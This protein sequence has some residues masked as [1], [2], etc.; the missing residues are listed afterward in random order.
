MTL[1]IL[2][3]ET[4]VFGVD[5]MSDSNQN[6]L[7]YL[8]IVQCRMLMSR[9]VRNCSKHVQTD[10]SRDTLACHNTFCRLT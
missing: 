8:A 2:Y 4:T 5:C 10:Y 3:Q 1:R 9:Y 7:T 6:N